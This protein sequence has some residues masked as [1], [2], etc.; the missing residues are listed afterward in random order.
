MGKT[1]IATT[2]QRTSTETASA[3]AAGL[4]AATQRVLHELAEHAL[5]SLGVRRG[6]RSILND[7]V[8][9]QVELLSKAMPPNAD[10][11]AWIRSAAERA[12]NELE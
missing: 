7:E 5:R 8:R 3:S 6:S 10:R 9:R 11:D 4:S 1:I 12:L 2:P